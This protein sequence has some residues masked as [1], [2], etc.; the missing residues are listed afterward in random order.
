ML[1]WNMHLKCIAKTPCQ[2][3]FLALRSANS[4][5]LLL[6]GAQP[7]CVQFPQQ[8]DFCVEPA[9]LTPPGPVTLKSLS[10]SL[11]TMQH[12]FT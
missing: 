10:S 1:I 9:Q 4:S 7:K 5:Y 11:H 12:L 6:T 2:Y 8:N 3:S